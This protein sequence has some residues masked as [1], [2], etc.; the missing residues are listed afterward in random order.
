MTVLPAPLG[1]RRSIRGEAI[2]SSLEKTVTQRAN[3]VNCIVAGMLIIS[4]D[5]INSG[6]AATH[7]AA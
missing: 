5:E 2:F 3:R 1:A 4:G 7:L 6:D